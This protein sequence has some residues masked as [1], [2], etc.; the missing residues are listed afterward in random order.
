MPEPLGGADHALRDFRYVS[1]LRAFLTLNNFELDP[2]SF[3][4]RFESRT[5]DCAEVDEY[6]GA[7][8]SRDEA[9]SLRVVE[10]LYRT[11]DACHDRSLFTE[12]P[13]ALT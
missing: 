10:P 12:H 4:K 6:V 5:G 9:K 13:I 3:G 2:I 1:S 7:S 8:L 11:R